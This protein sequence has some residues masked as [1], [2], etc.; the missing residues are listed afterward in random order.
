MKSVYMKVVVYSAVLL[1]FSLGA[2]LVIS[3]YIRYIGQE[4]DGAI[5][6][7]TRAQFM[8]ARA[9]YEAGGQPAI[10]EY[11][12]SQEALYPQVHYYLVMNG[13]DLATG[14]DVS[15]LVWLT[16]TPLRYVL[17]N[18]E[19]AI[20]RR[21]ARSSL[22]FIIAFPSFG[23]PQVYLLFFALVALVVFGMCWIL[24]RSLRNR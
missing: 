5:A 1:L 10:A 17:L 22:V 12:K 13:R 14:G 7:N 20:A 9:A 2:V 16:E 8:A 21:T 24:H 18:R 4:G 15:Q 6:Q 3:R 11:I 19:V 23:Q